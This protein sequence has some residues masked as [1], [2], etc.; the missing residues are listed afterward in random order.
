MSQEYI[1][2]EE[3]R[4][5]LEEEDRLQLEDEKLRKQEMRIRVEEYKRMRS[6]EEKLVHLAE[7]NKK[8]RNEFVNSAKF[9]KALG[10]VAPNKRTHADGLTSESNHKVSWV[11]LKKTR[12]Y[13]NDPCMIERLK[14]VKPWKE[15]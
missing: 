2:E 1:R 11:K 5:R 10:R 3:L 9:K 14:N 13:I 8:K 4:L 15:V 7:E 6:E 12:G